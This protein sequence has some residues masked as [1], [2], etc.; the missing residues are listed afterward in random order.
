MITPSD[1]QW[2]VIKGACEWYKTWKADGRQILRIFGFAGVGKSA[3]AKFIVQELNLPCVLGAAYSG[4]AALQM[5]VRGFEGAT[6]IHSIIYKPVDKGKGRVPLLEAEIEKLKLEGANLELIERLERDLH[7]EI[8]GLRKM[9]WMLKTDSAL[10]QASLLVIDE[11]SMAGATIGNDLCSFGVPIIALGDPA[12][13]PPVG[14]GGFFTDADPDFMLTQ[15]HRQAADSA[16]IRM[17]TMA[18]EDGYVPPGVYRDPSGVDSYVIQ[19][20]ADPQR[21]L[22]ADQ[23][24]VG[25]NVTRHRTNRW[26]RKQRGFTYHLPEERD[27][28]VCLRNDHEEGLLN[29]GLFTSLARA[30]DVDEHTCLV[31]VQSDDFP[32]S[33]IKT[34]MAHKR[35]FGGDKDSMKPWEWGTAQAFD[36]APAL[37]V[38]KAQGSEWANVAFK[39]EWKRRESWKQF[40]YT[41]ITRAKN[42][43]YVVL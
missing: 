16:I 29:G 14:D 39:A 7:D 38:H 11:C 4:K 18:R 26:A 3:I 31:T 1:A 25:H 27:R 41:G 19:G 24:L 10:R 15:I 17:A 28:L 42:S 13:L 5:R 12:Q 22:D 23:I 2:A 8:N 40:Y 20:A 37:T 36:F 32:E 35:T 34:L 21:L 9:A 30:E 6:T 33:G 43:L